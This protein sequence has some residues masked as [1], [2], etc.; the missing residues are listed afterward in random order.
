MVVPGSG[1]HL[2][3]MPCS[4]WG[5]CWAWT[6]SSAH[7]KEAFWRLQALGLRQHHL[8]ESCY[9]QAGWAAHL[10][11]GTVLE[12]FLSQVGQGGVEAFFGKMKLTRSW[13]I[14]GTKGFDLTRGRK[15]VNFSKKSE[16]R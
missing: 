7:L 10:I 2:S 4:I 1:Q 8:P 11:A 5:V 14:S 16:R 13:G 6:N 3:F 9:L 12:L 15:I